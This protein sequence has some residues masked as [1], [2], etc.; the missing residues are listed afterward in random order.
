MADQLGTGSTVEVIGA[1]RV[2]ASL[3]PARWDAMPK[4][5]LRGGLA[6]AAEMQRAARPHHDT[7]NLERRI[8]AEGPFGERL[9]A[10]V[11][12]GISTAAAPEGRPLAFG[13]LSRTGRRPPTEAIMKW[14]Q[15]HPQSGP[16]LSE[17]RGSRARPTILNARTIRGQAGDA[18]LRS[19]AFLIA[20][21]IG[22][23][24]YRFGSDNWFA[25][26]IVA[27]KPKLRAILAA[28]LRRAGSR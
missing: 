17:L 28:E 15:R 2:D 26:G 19:R 8:H 12:I 18:A 6:M 5:L 20:R 23:R 22:R 25:K 3:A 24:G 27:G 21:A 14:L 13:W 9:N 16:D 4:A 7:G 10:V 1:E 11:K